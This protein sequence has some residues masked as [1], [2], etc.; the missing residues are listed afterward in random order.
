VRGAAARLGRA[1][2]TLCAAAPLGAGLAGCTGFLHSTAQPEQIYYL[3][4]LPA[5]NGGSAAAAPGGGFTAAANGPATPAPGTA[6][7]PRMT[8]S[9]RVGHPVADPGLDTPHIMLVQADHRMNFYAGSRWPAP[10]PDVVE[11]LAVETL[12]GSGEWASVEDSAS[13]FPS[14]YLLQLA[15]RRFDADYT[16]GSGAVPTVQVTIDCTLGRREGRDVIATF[17]ASG[18]APATANRLANVVGAFE[19]ATDAALASL[20]QQATQA[21]RADAPRAAQNEDIPAPSIRR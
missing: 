2:R 12:R 8:V 21:V 4:A 14:D 5:A 10:I 18:S 3:R 6:A 20:A 7:L 17:V 19:Q 1:A 9:L 15:V 11:A 16:E 13:P